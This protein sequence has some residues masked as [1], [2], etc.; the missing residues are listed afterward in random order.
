MLLVM[1]DQR[2]AIQIAKANLLC[3][4]RVSHLRM[5]DEWRDITGCDAAFIELSKGDR[6]TRIRALRPGSVRGDNAE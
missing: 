3:R 5:Q 6:Y 4:Q 2:A 1:H